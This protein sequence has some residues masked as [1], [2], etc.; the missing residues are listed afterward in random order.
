MRFLTLTFLVLTLFSCSGGDD[1]NT[2]STPKNL[3]VSLNITPGTVLV[4]EAVTI[5]V[6]VSNASDSYTIDASVDGQTIALDQNNSASFSTATVGTHNVIVTVSDSDETKEVTGSFVVNEAP[7]TTPLSAQL[8]ISPKSVLLNESV[9]ISVAVS[10]VSGTVS[11]SASVDGQAITLDQNFSAT[12]TATTVGSHSVDVVVSDSDETKNLN[13]TF[14]VSDAP[15]ALSASLSI[16]PNAVGLGQPVTISVAVNNPTGAYTIAASV[17]DQPI[18]LGQ[19]NSVDFTSVIVGTHVVKA[20]VT[21]TVNTVNLTENFTVN[22]PSIIT[23]SNQ[24][25]A[26]SG[27][28]ISN[29][30]L[31]PTGTGY[32]I[33]SLTTIT[34][35]VATVSATA[36]IDSM[37]ATS[38]AVTS[39]NL[40]LDSIGNVISTAGWLDETGTVQTPPLKSDGS[41]TLAESESA[42]L[43]N[44]TAL[45]TSSLLNITQGDKIQL[46]FVVD[47]T[48]ATPILYPKSSFSSNSVSTS[49]Y[50]TKQ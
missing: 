30:H 24:Q 16:S 36:Y 2:N 1:G 5:S 19:N 35:T 21:D 37:C 26:L 27:T 49:P 46:Y 11:V 38:I 34:S 6:D 15:I 22:P 18:T 25:M 12:Y 20:T 32:L 45:T 50:Y 8:T 23:I 29:C 48:G 4:N 28:F 14:M 3:N 41:G 17:D 9:T 10:N 43:L 44:L 42:T 39:A 47:D 31:D 13:D 40:S 7:V 33:L